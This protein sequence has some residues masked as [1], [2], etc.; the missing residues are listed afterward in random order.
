MSFMLL[1]D[2]DKR[3]NPAHTQTDTI[4]QWSSRK[5]LAITLSGKITFNKRVNCRKTGAGDR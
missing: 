5:G 4:L 1:R 3:N 2:K